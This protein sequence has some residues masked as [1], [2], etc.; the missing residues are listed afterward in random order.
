MVY[1]TQLESYQQAAEVAQTLLGVCIDSSQLYRLATY[2]GQAIASDLDQPLA[3]EISLPEVVYVQADGCMILTEEG[4]KETK[5][6]RI[7][8]ASDLQESVVEERGGHISASLYTAHLGSAA[9]FSVKL[10]PHLNAYESLGS[11]LVFISDGAVWLRR[12]MEHHCPQATL[13]L[14][15]YHAASYIGQAAQAAFGAGVRAEKWLQEQR[16]LLI[17]SHLDEV[18]IHLKALPIDSKL[19]NSIEQYLKANRDRMDYAAYRQRGLLIGSG[20][21]E[22]A[23]RTVIQKRLKRAGQRW[24]RLGAQYVLNLRVCAMSNRWELV[25]NRIEPYPYQSAA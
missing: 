22:S 21:I 25:R 16:L 17:D 23:H 3:D 10:K 2:Y 15:L 14:D 13:I 5:L 12:L 4:Y 19:C 20:A 11:E 6:A 8:K 24:S 1:L 7:F 9:D 18:L